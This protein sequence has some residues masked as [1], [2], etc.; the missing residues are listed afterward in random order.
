MKNKEVKVRV[1]YSPGFR[2]RITE[3]C[4]R[5]LDQRKVVHSLSTELSTRDTE[6]GYPPCMHTEPL[7]EGEGIRQA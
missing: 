6:G 7:T 5:E 3:A 1:I 2:E 4:L